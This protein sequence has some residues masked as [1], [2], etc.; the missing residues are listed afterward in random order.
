MKRGKLG[1][2][3]E[4]HARREEPDAFEQPLDVGVGDLQAVHAEPGGDL[5]KLLA[6]T[7]RRSR[8][9]AAARG[10][11]TAAGA[12]HHATRGAEARSVICTFPVSR[13]NRRLPPKGTF[14]ANCFW[15]PSELVWHPA[16]CST[17]PASRGESGPVTWLATDPPCGSTLAGSNAIGT[18]DVFD[19]RQ[20]SRHG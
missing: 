8:A 14:P 18:G 10:C 9:G 6:R 12:V 7:R 1:V 17:V 19:D 2:E 15:I 16:D 5:R 13:S 4:L 20:H 3:L 11:S